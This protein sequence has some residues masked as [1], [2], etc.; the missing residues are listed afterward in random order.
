MQVNLW[1]DF[2]RRLRP[3]AILKRLSDAI[4]LQ[5]S[6][7][8]AEY[9]KNQQLFPP[10]R[11]DDDHEIATACRPDFIPFGFHLC[12]PGAR[13]PLG[14]TQCAGASMDDRALLD[15]IGWVTGSKRG[16]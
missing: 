12:A 9:A 6:N 4:R 11:S 8:R 7:D 15:A 16:A 5:A 10:D 1:R 2:R 14:S 13:L 3:L